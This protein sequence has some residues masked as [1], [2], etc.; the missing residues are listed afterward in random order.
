[1]SRSGADSRLENILLVGFF[2][3]GYAALTYEQVWI[4]LLTLL[5]GGGTLS[6]S[7]LLGGFLAGL[8]LGSYTAGRLSSRIKKPIFVLAWIELCVAITALMVIP[9]FQNIDIAYLYFVKAGG[10]G[11]LQNITTPLVWTS[12]SAFLL[13]P[14]ALL[15]AKFSVA[16]KFYSTTRKTRGMDMGR[17]YSSNTL[18]AVFGAWWTGFV[19]TP[20]I[21]IEKTYVAATFMNVLFAA[22]LFREFFRGMSENKKLNPFDV[23]K[24]YF[25]LILFVLAA[26]PMLGHELD[27]RYAG[28][29]YIAPEMGLDEWRTLKKDTE[30]LYNRFSPFGLVTVGVD[31][32][33]KYLSVDGKPEASTGP[34]DLDGQYTL[35]YLPMFAHSNPKKV[36][37]IGAGAGFTL[38][39]VRNFEV[40]RVDAVEINPLALQAAEA[41]FEEETNNVFSD[42]RIN[43]IVEDGRRFLFATDELYDV[44]VTTPSNPWVAGSSYLFTVEFYEEARRHL[45]D[46]GIFSAWAPIYEFDS[47]DIKIYLNTLRAA[48]PEVLVFISGGDMIMLASEE[49]IEIDYSRLIGKAEEEPIKRHLGSIGNY[50]AVSLSGEEKILAS[51]RMNTGDLEGFLEETDISTDDRPVLEFRAAR[52]AILH[53][54]GDRPYLDL[55]HSVLEYKST[56]EP[57]LTRVISDEGDGV[58]IFKPLMLKIAE[59]EGWGVLDWGYTIT[60]LPEPNAYLVDRFISYTLPDNG[61]L[62]A[63]GLDIFP[64]PERSEI[65]GMLPR[66]LAAE[67]AEYL[68]VFETQPYERSIYGLTLPGGVMGESHIWYCK[69]YNRLYVVAVAYPSGT[70]VDMQEPLSRAACL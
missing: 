70:D 56:F 55:I 24:A 27:T 23:T 58:T 42:P 34:L 63:V 22:L 6:Y 65:D 7:V 12:L 62:Y 15:G 57:P 10:T 1:M 69:R 47:H 5:F 13:L 20:A 4:Q 68:G 35:A 45:K 11:W 21:G 54:R 2:L 14:T 28:V 38:D 61:V 39:A 43:F 3:S 30:I 64:E 18:G 31:A 37:H 53:H 9:F 41:F 26:L 33:I 66:I 16:A 44:I 60:A 51:Y 25:V 36:L 19:F 29:Y 52:Q 40:E 49:P 32:G 17:L 50:Y 59:G 8:G 67:D 46:G 48:F